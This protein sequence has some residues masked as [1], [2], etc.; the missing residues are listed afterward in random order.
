[1][2]VTLPDYNGRSELLFLSIRGAK[3]TVSL[4]NWV[5]VD[6]TSGKADSRPV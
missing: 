2:R 4:F 5:R 3:I 1:M 6:Q